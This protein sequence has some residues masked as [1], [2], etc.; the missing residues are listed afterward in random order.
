MGPSQFKDEQM[1]RYPAI[2]FNH[3]FI[4]G[5]TYQQ[6]VISDHVLVQS[7]SETTRTYRR[8]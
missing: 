8:P 3:Q 1:T 6:K 7:F 5:C 2:L 4:S